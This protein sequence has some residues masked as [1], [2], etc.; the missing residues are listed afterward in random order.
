MGRW[1]YTV[2][3]CS[4]FLTAWL[5]LGSCKDSFCSVQSWE[6]DGGVSGWKDG[7]FNKEQVAQDNATVDLY[8]AS[9]N[10]TTS[11]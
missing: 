1:S 6:A 10:D 8:S 9:L 2:T 5:L 11:W 3:G 4:A 7:A